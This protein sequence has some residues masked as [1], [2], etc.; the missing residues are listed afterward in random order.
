MRY[1]CPSVW[2]PD[3][4]TPVLSQNR[5]LRW[6][7]P[8]GTDCHL[9]RL[10]SLAKLLIMPPLRCRSRCPA[11][12]PSPILL[13][14]I[15]LSDSAS[16]G[17]LHHSCLLFLDLSL[18]SLSLPAPLFCAVLSVEWRESWANSC[19][20]FRISGWSVL[21]PDHHLVSFQLSY[22][23]ALLCKALQTHQY[24]RSTVPDTWSGQLSIYHPCSPALSPP[25]KTLTV[26]TQHSTSV[27]PST[28]SLMK[29]KTHQYSDQSQVK[30]MNRNFKQTLNIF[31][32]ASW[33]LQT[34]FFLSCLKPQI[35][36]LPF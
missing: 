7:L 18:Q 1:T 10:R 6:V 22:S 8:D 26:W 30:F 16:T 5:H 33:L 34:L 23:A 31:I 17:C 3:C 2:P 21:S 35:S 11:Q 32:Y 14:I 27:T 20:P 15:I 29:E 4:S 28:S 24:F 12:S 19:F 9:S 13:L 36:S 25:C